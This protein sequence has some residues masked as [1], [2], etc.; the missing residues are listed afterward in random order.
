MPPCTER[1]V[2]H[3]KY[4]MSFDR[5]INVVATIVLSTPGFMPSS[6]HDA[7]PQAQLHAAHEHLA[8]QLEQLRQLQVRTQWMFEVSSVTLRCN[9]CACAPSHLTET[10][11]GAAIVFW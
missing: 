7:F 1:L 9:R 8:S 4:F 5:A 11:F 10:L 6:M 3:G 2:I